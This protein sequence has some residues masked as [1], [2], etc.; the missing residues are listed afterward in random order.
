MSRPSQRH[1]SDHATVQEAVRHPQ[2]GTETRLDCRNY[3]LQ[4]KSLPACQIL[5]DLSSELN[6][7]RYRQAC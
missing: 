6:W 1:L 7:L 2:V 5:I 4:L 3:I